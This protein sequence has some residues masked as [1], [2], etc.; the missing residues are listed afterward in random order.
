MT[1]LTNK[2]L[3]VYLRP[4]QLNA[5][6]S[7]ARRRRVAMSELVRQGVDEV[8]AGIDSDEDPLSDIVGM[9]DSGT[10]D[11]AAEHDRHLAEIY[12]EERSTHLG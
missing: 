3:Q 5:L 11:L 6:R 12:A 4:E 9:F 1:T 8:L 2:P 10:G 7:L